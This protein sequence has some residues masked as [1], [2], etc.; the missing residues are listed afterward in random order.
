MTKREA[1][2]SREWTR[3]NSETEDIKPFVCSVGPL[4]FRQTTADYAD[5]NGRMKKAR[6]NR[7]LRGWHG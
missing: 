3:K 6:L 5:L 4:S 2:E 1:H 7:G